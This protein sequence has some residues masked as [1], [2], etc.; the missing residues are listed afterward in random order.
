MVAEFNAGASKPR[1]FR[2]TE[3][4]GTPFDGSGFT[5]DIEVLKIGGLV[6]NPATDYVL[7]DVVRPTDGNGHLYVVTVAGTSGT[8]EPVWPSVGGTPGGTVIDGTVE[9]TEQTPTVAWS[10]AATGIV[11][12]DGHELLPAGTSYRVVYRV[13]DGFGD[14]DYFPNKNKYDVWRVGGVIQ[15]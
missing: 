13:T 12:I 6:W 2:L 3:P 4:P 14:C 8:T 11:V 9:F 1:Y 7:G 10:N 5:V 15:A